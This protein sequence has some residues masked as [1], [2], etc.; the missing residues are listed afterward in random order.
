MIRA[1]TDVARQRRP[2]GGFKAPPPVQNM[3]FFLFLPFGASLFRTIY[4]GP[5]PRSLLKSKFFFRTLWKSDFKR[6]TSQIIWVNPGP[7]FSI[8]QVWSGNLNPPV[9]V[10]LKL[11]FWCRCI[12]MYFIVITLHFL[13]TREVA[14]DCFFFLFAVRLFLCSCVQI[15][16]FWIPLNWV[17]SFFILAK[18]LQN[19]SSQVMF[20]VFC[21][22]QFHVFWIW[23][24]F[25]LCPPLVFS[26]SVSVISLGWTTSSHLQSSQLQRMFMSHVLETNQAISRAVMKL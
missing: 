14:L 16:A 12:L 24:C 17:T 19:L 8:Q 23:A 15:K 2:F 7:I 18:Y 13:S 11:D 1:K 22:L 5:F 4:A 26:S 9:H 10:Q 6:V 21:F 3:F 20:F 25:L